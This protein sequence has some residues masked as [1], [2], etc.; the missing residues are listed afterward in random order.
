MKELSLSR[1]EIRN[2]K[3]T[4]D[5]TIK[6]LKSSVDESLEYI[7]SNFEKFSWK[8]CGEKDKFSIGKKRVE[9][10]LKTNK[11]EVIEDYLIS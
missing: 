6:N 11:W 3:N 7:N 2:M 1:E 10:S 8:F 9:Q 5:D 4:L